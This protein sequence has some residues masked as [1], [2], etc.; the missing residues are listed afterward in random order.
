VSLNAYFTIVFLVKKMEK[1][2]I[3]MGLGLIAV[4]LIA[5]CVS[6]AGIGIT[7]RYNTTISNINKTVLQ[8]PGYFANSL[9]SCVFILNST[10]WLTCADSCVNADVGDTVLWYTINLLN[11]TLPRGCAKVK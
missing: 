1:T 8:C 5:G 2:K 10:P 6:E 9:Q 4:V 7:N 3:L 11:F